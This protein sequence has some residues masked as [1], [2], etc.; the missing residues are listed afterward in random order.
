MKTGIFYKTE[1]DYGRSWITG[2][3]YL[4]YDYGEPVFTEVR[5]KIVQKTIWEEVGDDQDEKQPGK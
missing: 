4:A 5:P 3:V 2:K 1:Y